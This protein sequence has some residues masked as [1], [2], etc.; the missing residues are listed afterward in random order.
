MDTNP[1]MWGPTP[2]KF[3]NMWLQHPNF[4][5]TLEIGGAGFKET[6]GKVTSS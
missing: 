5:R 2:F 3:E 6:D 4:K 1:F